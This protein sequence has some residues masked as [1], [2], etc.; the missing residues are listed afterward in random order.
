MRTVQDA[1]GISRLHYKRLHFNFPIGSTNHLSIIGPRGGG[2]VDSGQVVAGT[3]GAYDPI[4][5]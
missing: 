1:K 5:I 4:G 3:G 2:G